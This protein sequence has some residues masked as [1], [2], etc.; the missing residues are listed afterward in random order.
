MVESGVGRYERRQRRRAESE[1]RLLAEAQHGD[2]REPGPA[3]ARVRAEALEPPLQVLGEGGGAAVLV[4]EHEHADAPRLAVALCGEARPR[5]R[6]GGVAQGC[7]EGGELGARPAAE[8]RER[9]VQVLG[10]DDPPRA[11][12]RP[13]LPCG[14]GVGRVRGKANAEE[15]PKALIAPDAS[16]RRGTTS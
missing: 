4:A 5:G 15:E 8:E 3:L 7:R 9:D 6:A 11:G 13:L 12:E 10:R 16:G 1:A 14:E 2:V